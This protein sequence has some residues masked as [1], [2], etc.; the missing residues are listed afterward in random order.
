ME[1]YKAKIYPG[2]FMDVFLFLF[3]SFSLACAV[4]GI[5]ACFMQGWQIAIILFIIPAFSYFINRIFRRRLGINILA[6]GIDMHYLPQLFIQRGKTMH[7]SFADVADCINA[8]L[9]FGKIT[10]RYLIILMKNG[11]QYKVLSWLPPFQNV[12]TYKTNCEEDITSAFREFSRRVATP[13]T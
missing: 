4:F 11:K 12:E 10:T 7:L 13:Q 6:D 2:K 3:T 1:T 5:M 9:R 8:K